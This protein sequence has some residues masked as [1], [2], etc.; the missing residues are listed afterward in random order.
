M[1]REPFQFE[2]YHHSRHDAPDDA[3]FVHLPPIPEGVSEADLLDL[4]EGRLHGERRAA[5]EA[6]LTRQGD[7]ALAR[8]VRGM[9][10]DHAALVTVAREFTP[11]EPSRELVEKAVARAERELAAEVA[12]AGERWVLGNDIEEPE[13]SYIPVSTVQP[14]RGREGVLASFFN[15]VLARRF[16]VAAGVLLA[17]G[18]GAW[19]VIAIGSAIW[20]SRVAP[21]GLGA[22]GVA[23]DDREPDESTPR[24]ALNGGGSGQTPL[25][26][27]T[28]INPAMEES[29]VVIAMGGDSPLVKKIEPTRTLALAQEGKLVLKVWAM[30]GRGYEA[31]LRCDALANRQGRG[32]GDEH[33]TSTARWGIGYDDPA[34]LPPAYAALARPTFVDTSRSPAPSLPTYAG[35]KPGAASTPTPSVQPPRNGDARQGGNL[36]GVR[37]VYL[38]EVEATPEALAAFLADMEAMQGDLDD[39][40]AVD[41]IGEPK[42]LG[43]NY[44]E[45]EAPIPVASSPNTSDADQ[46]FWWNA[47][48]DRW[49]RRVVVPV[50]VESVE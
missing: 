38:V 1:T 23:V 41:T 8:L 35:D 3:A 42:V 48:A 33:A 45:S 28:S 10:A 46:L 12:S 20:P 34:S 6:A 21:G 16:A 37:R 39:T 49:V 13:T 31:A 50:V 44:V 17:V 24:V 9:S 19:G 22:G 40:T 15:G 14:V 11:A 18:V 36:W 25:K 30:P 29:G 43:V 26:A 32:G 4:V 2:D 47:P 27:T 7:P 5:V